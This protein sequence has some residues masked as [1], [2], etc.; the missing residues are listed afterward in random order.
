MV[1]LKKFLESQSFN[2][3]SL[4]FL[5][6]FGVESWT[7]VLLTYNIGSSIV[8]VKRKI[9]K[10]VRTMLFQALVV[11]WNFVYFNWNQYINDEYIELYN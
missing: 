2:M 6:K 3:E 1:C 4:E 11:L 7:I 9:L 10:N 5:L 8:W